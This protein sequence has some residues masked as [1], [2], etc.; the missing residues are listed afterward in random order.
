M[1][2]L[3]LPCYC[4][5]ANLISLENILYHFFEQAELLHDLDLRG[6]PAI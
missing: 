6:C 1:P 3:R 5:L 2:E 4:Q